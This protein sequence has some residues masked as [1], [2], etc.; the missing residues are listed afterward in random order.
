MG[1][2]KVVSRRG[3]FSGMVIGALACLAAQIL[4]TAPAAAQNAEYPCVRSVFAPDDLRLAEQGM[5]N[6][7]QYAAQLAEDYR[8]TFTA[9]RL[10][11]IPKLYSHGRSLNFQHQTSDWSRQFE[12]PSILRE[13][14]L[15]RPRREDILTHPLYAAYQAD[16]IAALAEELGAVDYRTVTPTCQTRY[17]QPGRDEY[18]NSGHLTFFLLADG[19]ISR[20]EYSDHTELGSKSEFLRIMKIRLRNGNDWFGPK[21]SLI[22]LPYMP[23][24]GRVLQWPDEGARRT[25]RTRIYAAL[26]GMAPAEVEELYF[27][28]D[29]LEKDIDGNAVRCGPFLTGEAPRPSQLY[30]YIACRGG[31]VVHPANRIGV[32]AAHL[33]EIQSRFSYYTMVLRLTRG[34]EMLYLSLLQA[35][36]RRAEHARMASADRAERAAQR[37]ADSA[38]ILSG[39]LM[40][41]ESVAASS[42]Q[43]NRRAADAANARF[44]AQYGCAAGSCSDRNR[45]SRYGTFLTA[46]EVGARSPRALG[47]PAAAQSRGNGGSAAATADVELET[48]QGAAGESAIYKDGSPIRSDAELCANVRPAVIGKVIESTITPCSCTDRNMGRK[49]R[50][51]RITFDYTVPKNPDRTMRGSER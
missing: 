1:R 7:R 11:D 16:L 30:A 4:A 37:R 12:P 27:Y 43:D 22:A 19:T 40:G 34:T 18:Y 45:R 50:S 31:P 29:L 26:T 5:A 25:E 36:E 28:R 13:P 2:Q 23:I 49:V 46:Q 44:Q 47:A 38:A 3:L 24:M 21:L 42:A 35:E 14:V 51:C 6:A 20:L 17:Q 33:A 8:T 10:I 39:V 32:P 41:L 48:L 9:E 15:K